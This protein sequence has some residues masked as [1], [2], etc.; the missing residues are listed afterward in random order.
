[1]C[2][3]SLHH[4]A[5]RPAKVSDKLVTTKL[6]KSSA[7]GFAAV[8]EHGAKL[9]IHDSPP[10]VAVC[11]LPGTELAFEDEVRYDRAFSLFGNGRI[12]HKV[13]RFRQIDVN[14]P[15]VQHDALEFPNGQVL[16][17]TRAKPPPCCNCR[18]QQSILSM[19]K[20]DT[21]PA[22]STRALP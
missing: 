8:G 14:D 5:S 16:K 19:L 7:R 1:M 20:P 3:Y 18:S 4:V 10:K 12:N 22:R 21:S 13:A 6:T 11:L 2:D 9:V 15:H 17:L